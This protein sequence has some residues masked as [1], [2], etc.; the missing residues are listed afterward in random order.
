MGGRPQA[1]EKFLV[2]LGN[3]FFSSFLADSGWR[4][5]NAPYSPGSIYTP[6][7]ILDLT[8]GEVPDALLAA[9][10]S[11]P[12]Y[13]L[14]MEN[15]PCLTL[16]YSVDAQ[17]HSWQPIYARGFDLCLVSLKE[18][19]PL[20]AGSGHAVAPP[21]ERRDASSVPAV[22]GSGREPAYPPSL[23]DAPARSPR[24]VGGQDAAPD[25]EHVRAAG[26]AA[27][28]AAP[29]RAKT[30]C[31]FYFPPHAQD[32]R[33]P[34][35]PAPDRNLDMVFVGT[36]DP[37]LAPQRCAF[38]DEL[39]E[40]FPALH[41]AQ[42]AF[43]DL[44]ARARLI[45][46]ECS[47]G[48]LNFRVFEAMGM[49]GCLLTPDIGPSLTE[50]FTPG[51]ELFTYPPYAVGPLIA[52]AERLLADAALREKV[53]AA[54][55]AAVDAGHRASHRARALADILRGL[56]SSGRAADLVAA[57]L[58]D[59]PQIRKHFLRPLY[60]HHAETIG[61]DFLRDRYLEAGKKR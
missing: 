28:F 40:K 36:L 58:R 33:R 43:A 52:L 51:E 47:R 48:E 57:R 11:A 26:F 31:V 20:F 6:E 18:Y 29:L 17:I 22:A 27:E 14:G 49:G 24:A 56:F 60:L 4:V 2:W 15:L 32:G 9:D 1:S 23:P 50:L 25:R 37:A 44:Y 42:G 30:G 35:V 13:L 55:L 12:P 5:L 8:G 10:A 54:G 3:P 46:N 16:F 59:A 39:R 34:P 45:L 53:A 61:V 19:L 41:V 7:S 21:P 38:I